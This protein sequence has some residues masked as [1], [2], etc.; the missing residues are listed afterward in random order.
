MQFHMLQIIRECC[1]FAKNI[2][3]WEVDFGLRFVYKFKWDDGSILRVIRK[4]T[5]RFREEGGLKF[6]M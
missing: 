2:K 3:F 6:S 4:I 5:S 1:D